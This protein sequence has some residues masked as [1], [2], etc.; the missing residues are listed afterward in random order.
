MACQS[1]HEPVVVL[2]FA[3]SETQLVTHLYTNVNRC[4]PSMHVLVSGPS[5]NV[6]TA[7]R[8]DISK[9]VSDVMVART[10]NDGR[11]VKDGS[12]FFPSG[13]QATSRT[14]SVSQVG[15]KVRGELTPLV[16]RSQADIAAVYL[17]Y[18]DWDTSTE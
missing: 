10:E 11:D 16:V 13:W 3:E 4:F 6:L 18:H 1:V 5:S 12:I 2:T 17:V 15:H 14:D 8:P 7:N 9:S